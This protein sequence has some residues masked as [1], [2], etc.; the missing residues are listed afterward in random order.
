MSPT[1]ETF[2]L[3]LAPWQTRIVNDFLSGRIKKIEKVLI[4]PGVI[5]CPA[6]YK[7]PVEGISKRDWVLYL[8]DEQMGIVKEKF[9][10]K[11]AVTGINITEALIKNKN[12]V[13]M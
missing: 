2:T 4:N 6:S 5:R 3:F 9:N 12:V 8:T 10:L 13:F 7:I 11:T 1:K